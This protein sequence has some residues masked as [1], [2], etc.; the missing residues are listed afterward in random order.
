MG[1][2]GGGDV[3]P[4]L[5]AGTLPLFSR[6]V[7]LLVNNHGAPFGFDR[8]MWAR[9]AGHDARTANHIKVLAKCRKLRGSNPAKSISAERESPHRF[10]R[11]PTVTHA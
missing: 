6:T 1:E 4:P 11:C 3:D 2:G 7:R 10:S 8:C 5:R 9:L